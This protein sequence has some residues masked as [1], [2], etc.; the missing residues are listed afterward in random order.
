MM[1]DVPVLP[2]VPPA[3][4]AHDAD[5]A[6]V[7]EPVESAV[8]VLPAKTHLP[9]IPTKEVNRKSTKLRILTTLQKLKLR[10]LN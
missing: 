2:I 6:A 8:M 5:I 10:K 3:Q 7:A 9:E 4:T 1:E